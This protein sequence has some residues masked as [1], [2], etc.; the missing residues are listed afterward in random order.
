MLLLCYLCIK[1]DA[2]SVPQTCRGWCH[3]RDLICVGSVDCRGKGDLICVGS[4]DC[5]E[6]GGVRDRW[7]GLMYYSV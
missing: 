3:F 7:V 6:G 4:V 2:W 1:A 5:K